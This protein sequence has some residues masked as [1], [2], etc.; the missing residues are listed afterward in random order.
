MSCS[1][2]TN[3]TAALPLPTR[4]S[5]GGQYIQC[6]FGTGCTSGAVG[7][8]KGG[9]RDPCLFFSQTSVRYCLAFV[10]VMPLIASAKSEAWPGEGAPTERQALGS[11]P[12]GESQ[13]TVPDPADLSSM[14]L[15][16]QSR[17]CSCSAC[18]E[19]ET[20]TSTRQF[21][22]FALLVL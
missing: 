21:A 1:Q 18:N 16:V 22:S 7:N 17:R 5:P 14:S 11:P 8:A 9:K 20:R 4:Y 6:T 10:S 19:R 3:L 13:C 2:D 12:Q 15:P